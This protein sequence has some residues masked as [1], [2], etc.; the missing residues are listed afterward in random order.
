MYTAPSTVP[1]VQGLNLVDGL[2]VTIVHC[3]LWVGM[4]A[5]RGLWVVVSPPHLGSGCAGGVDD[6]DTVGG[7]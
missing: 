2:E 4:I 1:T 5:H 3:R 6:S 7:R